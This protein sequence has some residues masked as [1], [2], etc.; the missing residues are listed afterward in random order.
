MKTQFFIACILLA[1]CPKMTAQSWNKNPGD[2]ALFTDEPVHVGVGI[3]AP[4]SN[5]EVLSSQRLMVNQETMFGS[6]T[7]D[8]EGN[9]VVESR[10]GYFNLP[11]PAKHIV[12]NPISP[13]PYDPGNVGIGESD[14]KNAKLVVKSG[15]G[16][17]STNA[18]FGA[19]NTGISIQQNLPTLGFNQ[20][21][22]N[23]EENRPRFMGNG[24]AMLQYL[25][26]ENGVMT[27]GGLGYGD[28]DSEAT[29][30]GADLMSLT[31][32]GQL[33][34]G[35]GLP[36][37]KL[38]IQNE[39][40]DQ[41]A[42]KV[43][44]DDP[45]ILFNRQGDNSELGFIRAW[46]SSLFA[47]T[48]SRAGLEIGTPKSIMFSTDYKPRMAIGHDGRVIIGL[49]IG[50][51][52]YPAENFL[53]S[54]G[55]R[56]ICEELKVML[57]SGWADFVFEDDYKLMPLDEVEAAIKAEKHLPNIPSACEIEENGLSRRAWVL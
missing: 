21:R 43:T 45:L 16:K 4:K 3:K 27:W 36:A 23:S 22:D 20:Y 11:I 52:P 15:N 17:G 7:H 53:L 47:N 30:A 35:L 14:P 39:N 25:N 42:I 37:A 48:F 55:G 13:F 33:M 44:A 5:L 29:P 31:Q 26:P 2:N 51:G 40:R 8:A 56:V 1:F 9:F 10:S 54:V 38:H 34:V 12:L 57:R 28:R 19:G 46:S 32:S 50:N 18:I 41:P 24:F 49:G 6:F